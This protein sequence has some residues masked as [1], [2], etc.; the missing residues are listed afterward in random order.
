VRRREA[1][2]VIRITQPGDENLVG[3]KIG[4]LGVGFYAE[5]SYAAKHG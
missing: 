2:L 4:R 5:R 1:D 3:R